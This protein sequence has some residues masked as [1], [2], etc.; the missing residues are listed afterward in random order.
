M[1]VNE[2][3]RQLIDIPSVTGDEKAVGEFLHSHLAKLGFVVQR[4]EVAA[5]R[6]NVIATTGVT[7]ALCFQHTWTRYR[8]GF[9]IM[10]MTK[11]FMVGA[12]VTP[13][14]SSLPRLS[15]RSVFVLRGSESVGLLFTVDE[16]QRSLGAEYA[17]DF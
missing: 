16:E 7:P 13:R 11:E 5:D 9:A 10:T 4:Q 14:E 17:N 12:L 3:T 8:R 2:L 6:F 15:R 1:N